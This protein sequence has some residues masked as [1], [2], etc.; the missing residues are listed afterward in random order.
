MGLI[1]LILFALVSFSAS[2][3]NFVDIANG[4]AARAALELRADGQYGVRSNRSSQTGTY[5]ETIIKT[6]T[7][8]VR[9]SAT[10][11]FIPSNFRTFTGGAG[12]ADA[13]NGHFEVES[14]TTALGYG[15][16]Q[17]FRSMNY[18]EGQGAIVR[19]GAAFPSPVAA[20]WTG[21]GALSI[22][23][24]VAF[25][26]SGT[27]FGVWHRYGGRAEVQTL[28]IST[29]ATGS[30]N[31]TV[32]VNGT[33]LT[34]PLTNASSSIPYTAREIADYASANLS[35]W[36]SFQRGNDV[37]FVAQSDSDKTGAFSFSSSTAAASFAETTAG[38]S[39]TND[40]V[41]QSDFNGVVP[42][43]FDP[44]KGNSYQIAFQNGFGNIRYYIQAQNGDFV[45]AHTVKW[46]NNNTTHNFGN[47]SMKVGLYAYSIGAT[48][49]TTVRVSN[50]LGMFEGRDDSTRNP[51]AYSNTKS[52]GTTLTNIFT[53][54]VSNELNGLINQSEI[55]PRFLTIAN[56][57]TKSAVFDL[58]ANPAISG[59]PNYAKQGTK[60][61]SE[62]DTAGTTVSGG[63]LLA[64]FVLA[65]GQ[66]ATINLDDIE[67]Q[68]PS[69]LR[70][71][72]AGK[73]ASGS[74][75]DLI[76]ALTWFEDL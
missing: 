5:D 19:F 31:A 20:T 41:A 52:I 42:S 57:G 37:I 18:K 60:L 67:I 24:E 54:R 1:K 14:G 70:L 75:A 13:V 6:R 11:N 15:A 65:K 16:I 51:R 40:F 62:I 45:L 26:Y 49:S 36:N 21:V 58:R 7:P 12:S 23:D 50:I 44:T 38:V 17:S 28:T 10:Y 66:S 30:E 22:G 48:T 8:E 35:G 33:I 74:A 39:K 46:G 71:C 4:D 73:M 68:M 63:T 9:G 32:T 64:S 53:L 34:V 56:D 43:G 29:A 47:P 59:S 2:A 69:T 3:Q 25:G 61:I 76:A 55:R 27:S 72:I